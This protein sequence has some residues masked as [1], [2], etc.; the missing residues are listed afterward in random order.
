M[1][2]RAL[3]F[4]W[5]RYRSYVTSKTFAI[6][7]LQNMSF[8]CCCC[9]FSSLFI[10]LMALFGCCFHKRSAHG[11]KC[12]TRLRDTWSVFGHVHCNCFEGDRIFIPNFFFSRCLRFLLVIG[13]YT[14]R[15]C[16]I[17]DYIFLLSSHF[18]LTL[19]YEIEIHQPKC[20]WILFTFC[21][22][23]SLITMILY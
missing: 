22:E 8:C 7:V 17:S 4:A 12:A 21:K 11:K 1:C 23:R 3:P 13:L 6:I 20:T 9:L 10:Y 15:K 5:L 16:T 18:L 14:R 19:W 2:P